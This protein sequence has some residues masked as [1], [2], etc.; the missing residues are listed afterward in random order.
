VRAE[1]DAPIIM[2]VLP[3]TPMIGTALH[4]FAHPTDYLEPDWMW[5]EA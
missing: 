5:L 1:C 2:F 4:A 3:L